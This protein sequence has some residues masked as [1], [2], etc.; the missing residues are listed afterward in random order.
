[1]IVDDRRRVYRLR[2]GLFIRRH[3]S[4]G[5]IY[6]VSSLNSTCM[7]SIQYTKDCLCKKWMYVFTLILF[8]FFRKMQSKTSM[9]DRYI[10]NV[11]VSLLSFVL[12]GKRL[13]LSV[14]RERP[15]QDSQVLCGNDLM[16]NDEQL[17]GIY[18]F[19]G[20][21]VEYIVFTFVFCCHKF[22]LV[23][24]KGYWVPK[25]IRILC[26]HNKGMVTFIYGLIQKSLSVFLQNRRLS[27]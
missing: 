4:E 27:H 7:S 10:Y 20:R 22:S 14:D 23:V 11:P 12:G 1:M 24:L 13:L 17:C 18:V 9:D 5:R 2:K 6:S 15:K 19:F 16:W 26:D 21:R 3:T 8:Y 25:E